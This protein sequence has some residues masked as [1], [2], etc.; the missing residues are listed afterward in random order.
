MPFIPGNEIIG[1]NYLL[2]KIRLKKLTEI[3]YENK[4]VL[5]WKHDS[6]IKYQ[7]QKENIEKTPENNPIGKCYYLPHHPVIRPEKLTTKMGIVF[8]A[9]SKSGGEKSLH[10]Y[11]SDRRRLQ[12]C[13]VF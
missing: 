7:K 3:F 13:S 6:L 2:A 12:S 11:T 5:L 8:D 4:D 1:D 9:S 10:V